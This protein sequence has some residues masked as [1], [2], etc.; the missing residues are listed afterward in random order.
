MTGLEIILT[1]AVAALVAVNFTTSR[2]VYWQRQ[3]IEALTT[4]HRL[5]SVAYA[6]VYEVA[7]RLDAV[8]DALVRRAAER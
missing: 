8:T 6:R 2:L 1:A 5:D 3:H 7:E 4:T